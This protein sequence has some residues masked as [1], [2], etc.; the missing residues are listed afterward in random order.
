MTA[1]SLTRSEL[2]ELDDFL[3]S[4]ASSSSIMALDTLHGFLSAIAIG[5]DATP[6]E[7]WQAYVL[8]GNAGAAPGQDRLVLA[9]IGAYL[10]RIHDDIVAALHHPVSAFAPLV[11]IRS[12]RR[13]HYAD[14]EMWCYGF[15]QGL[16]LHRDGSRNFL[17]SPVG[18]SLLRPIYLLGSDE[19]TPEEEA[20]AATPRQRAALTAQI[21]AAVDALCRH[22]V[23]QDLERSR[24]G[25]SHEGNDRN[26]AVWLH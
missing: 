16:A 8:G 20:L 14:G 18:S 1:L 25:H 26:A 7:R 11:M 21:P 17:A 23:Q 4:G 15:L 22:L 24:A 10:R 19:V 6:A 12:F 2:Q 9:R 3:V 13:K 5:P